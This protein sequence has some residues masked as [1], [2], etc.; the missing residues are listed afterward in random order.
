[1]RIVVLFSQA[2]PGEAPWFLLPHRF[3]WPPMSPVIYI[4]RLITVCSSYLV[5][6]ENNALGLTSTYFFLQLKQLRVQALVLFADL[7]WR[8]C[9]LRLRT[10]NKIHVQRFGH[11]NI[12]LDGCLRL[13]CR[14]LKY[15]RRRTS[16][17][18]AARTTG[19]FSLSIGENCL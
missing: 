9:S 7:R 15:L 2:P 12:G 19:S 16:S 10:S 1:M 8:G 5:S 17:T 13:L 6:F 4:A 3:P 14:L 11:L 18:N